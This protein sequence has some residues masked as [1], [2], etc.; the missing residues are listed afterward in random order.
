MLPQFTETE[1]QVVIFD[2]GERRNG[3]EL[4]RKHDDV[5]NLLINEVFSVVVSD[6]LTTLLE[7]GLEFRLSIELVTEFPEQMKET[8]NRGVCPDVLNNTATR[9]SGRSLS[10]PCRK[11]SSRGRTVTTPKAR[12]TL[13]ILRTIRSELGP[14][15]AIGL[16]S[17]TRSAARPPDSGYQV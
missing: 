6:T 13:W 4:T 7:R 1:G 11:T 5:A 15:S 12:H 2:L 8:G 17:V 3:D 10:T 9:S 16:P 14:S